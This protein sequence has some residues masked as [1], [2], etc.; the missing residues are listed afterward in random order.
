MVLVN[1]KEKR[2]SRC[3]EWLIPRTGRESFRTTVCQCGASAAEPASTGSQEM[4]LFCRSGWRAF[5]RG[6]PKSEAACTRMLSFVC[7][8]KRC[9]SRAHDPW[10]SGDSDVVLPLL[11]HRMAGHAG[12]RTYRATQRVTGAP[13]RDT[14]RPPP[15]MTTCVII[16]TGRK[17]ARHG[18]CRHAGPVLHYPDERPAELGAERANRRTPRSPRASRR[19]RHIARYSESADPL[20]LVHDESVVVVL[21]LVNEIDTCHGGAVR[22]THRDTS[23]DRVRCRWGW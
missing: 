12:R 5:D 18:F 15:S 8:H 23:G 7:C 16:K 13:P 4:H 9:E 11:F 22:P 21:R 17:L 2:G 20:S 1:D 19:A 3:H 14:I 6:S 10:N